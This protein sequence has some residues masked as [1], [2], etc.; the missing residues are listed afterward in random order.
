MM[1]ASQGQ[2]PPEVNNLPLDASPEQPNT[3]E[4]TSVDSQE[5]ANI[6]WKEQVKAYAKIHRGTLLNRPEEKELGKKILAK[7]VPPQ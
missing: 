7:E 1:S 2:N 4:P 6:P 5:N 3:A